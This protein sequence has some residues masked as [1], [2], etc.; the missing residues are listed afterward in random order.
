MNEFES[1]KVVWMG[2]EFSFLFYN[3][4][5]AMFCCDWILSSVDA[6]F[7]RKIS[8]TCLIQNLSLL[9]WEGISGNN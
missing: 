3:L 9:S 2:G 7:L 1:M 8:N 4:N 6:N 5:F